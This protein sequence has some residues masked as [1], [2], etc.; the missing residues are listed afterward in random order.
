MPLLEVRSFA[1][2]RAAS[3]SSGVSAIVTEVTASV[4]LARRGSINPADAAVPMPTNANSPPGPS[5]KPVSAATG[6]DSRNSRAS[7]TSTID[8][9]A[10]NA[11]TLPNTKTGSRSN[12]RKSM[13]MPTVKKNRPSSRPLNGATVA[14]IALRYSVSAS[15]S[16]ATK[17]PSAIDSPA[18]LAITPAAMITNSAAAIRSSLEP[19]VAT[20][21]NSGRSIVRPNATMTK[22]AMAA[23]NSA[24]A[25][26]ANTERPLSAA[27]MET[28]KRIGTTARSCA[29][30]TEKLARPTLV[31]RRSWLDRSSSTIAVEDNDKLAPSMTACGGLLPASAAA[32]A[33]SALVS[34]TCE[35]PRPNTSR[36]IAVS[37]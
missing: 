33:M 10:I 2:P 9:T 23:C 4:K 5:N 7:S 30:S 1:S 26:L 28:N 27:R 29:S 11:T 36:R 17:A 8:L 35:P 14:S 16:P 13:F 15:M 19:P 32:P 24:L 3:D 12:S 22:M 31:V 37:R 20:R 34:N 25:R 6:H 18:W 21:R